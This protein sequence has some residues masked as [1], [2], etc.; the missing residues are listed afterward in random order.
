M[1][2]YS[3]DFFKLYTQ[4]DERCLE[5]IVEEQECKI[6]I[7]ENMIRA[8]NAHIKCLNEKLEELKH[9]NSKLE[10]ELEKE[11]KVTTLVSRIEVNTPELELDLEKFKKAMKKSKLYVLGDC[12]NERMKFLEEQHLS[13]C[14]TINQLQTTIDVLNDKLAKQES[15]YVMKLIINENVYEMTRKRAKAVLKVAQKSVGQGIFGVEKNLTLFMKNEKFNSIDE[16]DKQI[17]EYEKQG[18][19]VYY[20][21]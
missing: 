16:L 20:R 15:E 12:S 17:K 7:Y 13:D 2:D 19:K 3:E 4:E 11:E 21:R 1:I 9:I 8:G 10:K 6:Q 5:K 18:F 14:A